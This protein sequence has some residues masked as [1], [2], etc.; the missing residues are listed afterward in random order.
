MDG[1]HHACERLEKQGRLPVGN[2]VALPTGA[3]NYSD[4][5][6]KAR[7][8]IINSQ[9]LDGYNDG[10]PTTAPV[11]SFTPSK[12]GLYDMGGNV[13]E[14]VADWYDPTKLHRTARGGSFVTGHSDY[15]FSS[16]RSHNAPSLRSDTY[17]F[18][19]VIEVTQ[20]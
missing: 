13:A 5:S 20:P 12:A 8:P 14:W 9:Y 15:L 1:G 10:F 7:A 11:M 2:H 17:G 18:R 3:G 4:D 16:F 19:V 6:R